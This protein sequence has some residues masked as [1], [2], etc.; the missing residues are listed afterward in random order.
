M[1]PP[2]FVT[3]IAEN[4]AGIVALLNRFSVFRFNTH[5]F[6]GK[7]ALHSLSWVRPNLHMRLM[8]ADLGLIILKGTEFET[9]GQRDPTRLG[10]HGYLFNRRPEIYSPMALDN[11]VNQKLPFYVLSHDGL[12]MGSIVSPMRETLKEAQSN[13]KQNQK[14]EQNLTS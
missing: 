12:F 3:H 8:G 2:D 4:A 6:T 11:P 1:V 9:Q 7:D 13:Q 10:L 14:P 5:C